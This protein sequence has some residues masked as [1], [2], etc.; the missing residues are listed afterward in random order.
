MKIC[1][2]S[3]PVKYGRWPHARLTEA[4]VEDNEKGGLFV[5]IDPGVNYGITVI[6]MDYAQIIHGVLPAASLGMRGAT[7]YEMIKDYFS[8]LDVHAT[9][10]FAVVEGAAYSRFFGQVPLEE[11]RFGFFLGLL[12]S[13]FNVQ[14]SSPSGIRK[15]AFGNGKLSAVD[16]YP[17]M[18][19]N[20]A[21][22]VGCALAASV[23]FSSFKVM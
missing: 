5:G 17:T 22:S 11:V 3:K 10:N 7:V 8:M 15:I 14:I 16:V 6:N 13:G 12:H 23:L 18:N 19:Q 4:K 9:N 1:N 20:A 21:D 2:L